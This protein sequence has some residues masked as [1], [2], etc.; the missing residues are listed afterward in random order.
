[1]IPENYAERV[2]AAVLGKC[3]GVRL[4]AP[5]EAESWTYE[6]IRAVYGEKIH[7]YLR[8]YRVFGADDDV[9]GP[10]YFF[11]V[12]EEKDDPQLM[13]FAHAW[14]DFV[15]EDKGF[16]WWGGVGKSTSHTSY[17]LIRS[18]AP[19]PLKR[20]DLRG[21][22]D[23]DES[24]GGQIFVDF[25]GLALP[26]QE[27]RAAELGGRLA[28]VAHFDDGVS[29]GRFMAAANAAAFDSDTVEEIVLRA[30]RTIP[31]EG[32]YARVTKAVLDFFHQHPERWQDCRNMLEKEWGY[33][34]YS[35]VCPMIP[36]AGICVMA[37][38]YSGGDLN[39]G[40]EIATL[41]GWDT[42]C[43]AGNVGSILGAFG[44][45]NPIDACYR[46]PFHDTAILSGVSG[47]INQCDLPSLAKRIA[48]RGFELLG[49]P[50][51]EVLRAEEGLH[52][53]F[54][55]PGST[56]GM[57]V[58]NPFVLQLSNS[59]ER[60]FRGKRSLQAVFNRLQKG[61]ETRL[62]FKTFHT[63]AEF[64]DGRYSPVF[65]PRIYPGQRLSMQLFMEKWGGT[66]PLRLRPYVRTA[67]DHRDYEG[68]DFHLENGRWQ[69]IAFRIPEVD[70]GIIEEA[71]LRVFSDSVNTGEASRDLGRFFVD[72]IRVTGAPEYR[73]DFAQSRVELG[74]LTPFAHNRGQWTLEGDAIRAQC[75]ECAQS[76]TG[77]YTTG[78]V[79]LSCRTTP[80]EGG[81]CLLVRGMG[82]LRH[83]LAGLTEPGK[84]G[85][86]LGGPEGY[87]PLAEVAFEWQP[88]Q[89]YELK[90]AARGQ[91]VALWIDG[92]KIAEEK[93]P[94][95]HGMYGMALPGAGEALFRG[96]RVEKLS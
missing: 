33:D 64:E 92:Q 91:N 19:L 4:G 24:V 62:Y 42:D 14:V 70:G 30:L 88:G 73:L 38:L 31:E 50:V 48:R 47:E 43:N 39:R 26:G 49:Q 10:A 86:L 55:L 75:G 25:L 44:G 20:E 46:E 93:V 22:K 89:S 36:N 35:G 58:S 11:Q 29:G 95:D 68:E 80:L 63:R 61:M 96:M 7:G 6:R 27:Q 32:D 51:P 65:S 1:M 67:F 94:Y 66:E 40:V 37:L 8:P 59:G 83:V 18:G 17:H 60:S 16:F 12:L 41:A 71:G 85:I 23:E 76:F 21:L 69:E 54:E 2:Y 9:N 5:V 15:R 45:L 74:N 13:D 84:A 78:D 3:I 28:A 52:F 81:A 82:T 72:E 77:A 90:A 53:D 79:T 57:L 34:R 56:H 87:R